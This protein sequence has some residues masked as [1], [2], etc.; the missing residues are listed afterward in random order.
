MT[1]RRRVI[2]MKLIRL[3]ILLLFTFSIATAQ[4]EF[5]F[6]DAEEVPAEDTTAA[7]EDSGD[8]SFDDAETTE[9]GESAEVDDDAFSQELARKQSE[10]RSSIGTVTFR[11]TY[12]LYD[13]ESI[14]GNP[15]TDH[16]RIYSLNVGWPMI[17]GELAVR[18]G[19]DKKNYHYDP[20]AGF[21]YYRSNRGI[22]TDFEFGIKSLYNDP[23]PSSYDLTIKNNGQTDFEGTVDLGLDQTYT[24][25]TTGTTVTTSVFDSSQEAAQKDG[26]TALARSRYG[27]VSAKATLFYLNTY[28]HLTPLNYI[29]NFGSD[30]LWYDASLGP[31]LRVAHYGDY[32]DP[33]RMQALNNDNTRASFALVLR[34]YIQLH[35]RFRLRAH[36]YYPFVGELARLFKAPQFNYDEHILDAGVDIYL[37]KYIY[38]S[39][40]YEYHLWQINGS[41]EDRF[42]QSG[43]VISNREGLEI[44]SRTSGEFYGAIAFEW[45]FA[46]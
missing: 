19:K 4:E 1:L 33:A 13:F 35:S 34:Q 16:E 20:G 28:Y 2:D 46:P 41:S 30:F 32:G 39:F 29:L 9:G 17:G 14:Y 23:Q 21:S 10:S 43:D 15:A 12:G 6:S 27:A 3:F 37:I 44:K 40:G 42:N 11:M 18:L 38:L 8:I 36:Y 5:D 31:S 22:F 25:D 45:A 26:I 7:D 24:D